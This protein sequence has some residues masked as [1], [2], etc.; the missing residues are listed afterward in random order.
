MLD[1]TRRVAGTGSLGVERLQVLVRGDK[2]PWLLTVKEVRGSPADA[3]PPSA[4]RL[5]ELMRRCLRAPP[6]LLGASRL[7]TL[8]VIVSRTGPGEDKLSVDGYERAELL[9][10][11]RYLGYLTGDLHALGA[12]SRVRWSAKHRKQLFNVAMELAGLHQQAFLEFCLFS[13]ALH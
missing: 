6:V 2:H 11:C 9:P 4:E 5:V 13:A 8:P 1:C 3:Q 7:G 10:M 12:K